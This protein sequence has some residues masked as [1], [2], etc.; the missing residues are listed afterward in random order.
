MAEPGDA[1]LARTVE[2]LNRRNVETV[3]VDDGVQ[4]LSK[5]K[6]LVPEGSV[7]FNN[8]SATLDSIGY[9]SYVHENSNYR[10]LHDEMV[11]ETDPVIISGG[12]PVGMVLAL[13]LHQRG[14]PVKVLE[15]LHRS[16][17]ENTF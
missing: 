10:N 13:A 6:D 17:S 5:L 14:I 1:S 3:V 16:L 11:A 12:G 15:T 8:T 2:A 4:A 9:S 7:I